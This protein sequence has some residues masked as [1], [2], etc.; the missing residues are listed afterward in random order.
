MRPCGNNR[1][2]PVPLFP[3]RWGM[4]MP[5]KIVTD[6]TA[7]LPRDLAVELGITIV[8]LQIHFGDE[9]Y[10]DG[11][12]L[13]SSEFYRMLES[14]PALPKTSAPAPGV[15]EDVY[16]RLSQEADG[17]LSIHLSANLSATCQAANLGASNLKCPIC[18]LD[19]GSASMA[20]GLLAIL[21]AG[22][23]RAGGSLDEIRTMVQDAIPR[24]AVFGLFDTLDYLHK[25]GRIGKA[26]AFLGT[27]LK[28][29]PILEIGGGEILPA[30]RVRTRQ[31]AIERMCRLV[32][33]RGVPQELAVMDTTNPED[34]EALVELLSSSFPRERIYRACI[35]PVIGTYT[36][37]RAL[38][39][40]A[41]W[42]K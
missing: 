23:A 22:A 15:F 1:Q 12:D 39:I 31:K 33:E 42:E 27:L 26:Q 36:G 41:T 34:A 7:D 11:V 3:R 8:P 18:I 5:V 21:A 29:K 14:S 30:E 25:G 6:S 35:G 20:S 38:G 17:I 10:R 2:Y 4:I 28:V 9:V 37:P 16:R 32:L 13:T 24:T 19:S 40:A